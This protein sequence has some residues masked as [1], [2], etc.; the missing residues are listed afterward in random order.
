[1]L[2]CLVFFDKGDYTNIGLTDKTSISGYYKA[3][4]SDKKVLKTLVAEYKVTK[5]I[6]F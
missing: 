6:G 1:M 2:N 3:I 5:G 4:P